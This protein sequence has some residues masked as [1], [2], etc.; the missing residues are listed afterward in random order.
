[1][2]PAKPDPAAVSGLD[3]LL[4]AAAKAIEASDALA[5][6]GGPGRALTAPSSGQ[7]ER[8]AATLRLAAEVLAE[9]ADAVERLRPRP[10]RRRAK[11]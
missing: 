9:H 5:D 4:T 8:A 3:R 10:K 6:A 2:T 1:M 7:I 11:A